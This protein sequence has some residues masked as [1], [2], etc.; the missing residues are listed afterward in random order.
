MSF[1][2]L[3]AL[4]DAAIAS[5]FQASW[6]RAA[7]PGRR[8][9]APLRRRSV[10]EGRGDGRHRLVLPERMI[11]QYLHDFGDFS[12]VTAFSSSVTEAKKMLLSR[13]ARYSGL[14]DVLDFAEGGD[15]ELSAALG[16]ASTWIVVNADSKA[17]VGQLEA[18]AAAGV[19]RAFIHLSATE[20]SDVDVAALTAA[21]EASSLDYTVMRTGSM[22]KEGSGGGLVVSDSTCRRDEVPTDDEG[23]S[24]SRSPPSTRP[25]DAPLA[26]PSTTPSSRHAARGMHSAR[27]W[28]R[29]SRA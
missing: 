3:V 14:V 20:A 16:G 18:A 7:R 12:G 8:G 26:V 13:Q 27:R 29:C 28:R 4:Q 11:F 19:K 15:V 24:S 5:A 21:L 17:V 22:S 10:R 2:R 23:A 9:A 25:T 6:R 1:L